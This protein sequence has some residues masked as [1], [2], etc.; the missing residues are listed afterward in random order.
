MASPDSANILLD[1]ALRPKLTDFGL[2]RL[3]P[4]S[5]SQSCTITKNINAHSNLEY[6]PGEYIRD[7]K[8]SFSL[9]VYSFGMVTMT[10]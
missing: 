2:A 1:D 7:G 3:R 10:R 9:D 6:L 8:L 5:A 4:H